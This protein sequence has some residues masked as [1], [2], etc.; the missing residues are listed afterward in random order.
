MNSSLEGKLQE[1]KYEVTE[2]EIQDGHGQVDIENGILTLT[3]P[4]H[5]KV[6]LHITAQNV[7]IGENYQGEFIGLRREPPNTNLVVL[8]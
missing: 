2:I 1:E 8:K 4:G 5:E 6:G 7:Y 3:V